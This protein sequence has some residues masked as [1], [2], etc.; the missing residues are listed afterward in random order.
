MPPG[1][2]SVGLVVVLAG[3][4]CLAA[5]VPSH[6]QDAVPPYETHNVATGPTSLEE[7]SRLL[8][9]V[10]GS[11]KGA[12]ETVDFES[13]LPAPRPE[14]PVGGQEHGPPINLGAGR[15]RAGE[16]ASAA[17]GLPDNVAP[18][19]GPRIPLVAG[20]RSNAMEDADATGRP[21]GLSPLITAAGSLGVV[22]GLFL[23]VAWVIGR[24]VP[25]GSG[26]LP[27]EVVEVLG[28]AT[29]AGRGQVHLLRCGRKLL[30]VSVSPTGIESL[31]EITD[32]D[33]VNRLVGLCC[34]ARP[35]SATAVFQQV[36]QQFAQERTVPGI[37]GSGD[38]IRLANAG[39]PGRTGRVLEEHDV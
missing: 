25:G 35:G 29:L 38:D 37:S 30:L 27:K 20:D 6:G 21:N 32:P 9:A 39:I 28:R 31:T 24:A 5:G 4:V 14:T 15:P 22:L 17:S 2:K 11:R 3:S 10:T 1:A 23:L 13:P 18:D 19:G 36:L 34:Q 16:S 26:L 12:V 8:R 33:E 7:A